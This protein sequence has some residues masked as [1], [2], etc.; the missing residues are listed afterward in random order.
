MV[1]ET[2][3]IGVNERADAKSRGV[4]L[5]LSIA[6]DSVPAGR[7]DCQVTVLDLASQRAAFWRAPIVVVR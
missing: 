6:P 7:Y 4:P 2:P 1:F 5:R 3:P